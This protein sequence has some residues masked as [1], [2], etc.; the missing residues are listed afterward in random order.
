MQETKIDRPRNFA[1][2]ARI[3]NFDSKKPIL[4]LQSGD[5]WPYNRDIAGG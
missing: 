2:N 3:G 1:Q 4:R 5:K